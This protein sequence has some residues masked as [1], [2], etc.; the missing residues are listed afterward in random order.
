LD[1][2]ISS[3][4][5]KPKGD[6]NETEIPKLWICKGSPLACNN[7]AAG[8]E[9]DRFLEAFKELKS[10]GAAYTPGR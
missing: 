3:L 5:P 1:H 8:S 4:L 6:K 2:E 7:P 9:G 10:Q